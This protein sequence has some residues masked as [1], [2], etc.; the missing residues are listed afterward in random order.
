MVTEREHSR[1]LSEKFSQEE[2]EKEGKEEREKEGGSGT[3]E[4]S[5]RNKSRRRI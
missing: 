2:H 5:R 1:S 4:R 3:K